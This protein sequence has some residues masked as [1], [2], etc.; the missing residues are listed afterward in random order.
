MRK[1]D[2]C[3]ISYPDELVQPMTSS[4]GLA[5]LCGIC[6]LAL[7]NRVHG[8]NDKKFSGPQAEAIRKRCVQYRKDHP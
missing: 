3:E 4:L 6:A 5:H 8:T 7:K 2:E 1:C